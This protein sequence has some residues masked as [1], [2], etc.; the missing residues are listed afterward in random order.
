MLPAKLTLIFKKPAIQNL[1]QKLNYGKTDTTTIKI[2]GQLDT[3]KDGPK[4]NDT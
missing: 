2:P 3:L 4:R 1:F